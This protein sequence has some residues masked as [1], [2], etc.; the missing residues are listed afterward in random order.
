[1]SLFD[2]DSL[3]EELAFHELI[4]ATDGSEPCFDPL[5]APEDGEP[6]LND[7]PTDMWVEPIAKKMSRADAEALCAGCHVLEQCAT[8]ALLAG[9]A[10]GIWGGLRPQDR[11]VPARHK[12]GK[13][14][15]DAS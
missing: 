4:R 11:G 9:E 10:N 2:F 1:M 14:K 6:Y 15:P 8:Y 13:Y 12:G 5:L 7:S 3:E